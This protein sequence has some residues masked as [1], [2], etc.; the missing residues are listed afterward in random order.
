MSRTKRTPT[1]VEVTLVDLS[2]V[3]TEALAYL[4]A[5]R[6]T[7]RELGHDDVQMPNKVRIGEKWGVVE[8][9]DGALYALCAEGV[10]PD[11]PITD[12]QPLVVDVFIDGYE[13]DEPG[14][15][16]IPMF[17]ACQSKLTPADLQER[18]TG[19]KVNLA[20]FVRTF[21]ARLDGNYESWR[22]KLAS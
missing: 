3:E 6:Q 12:K 22:R 18:A 10:G 8:T 13:S 20:E 11:N 21:G 5:H 1:E 9:P 2:D 15:M 19:E 14:R 4:R 17:P 7:D 16:F